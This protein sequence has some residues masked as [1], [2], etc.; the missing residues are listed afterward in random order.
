MAAI[1]GSSPLTR[2]KLLTGESYGRAEWLIPAHA[3]KT[4]RPSKRR[5][6]GRAHPRSR[7]ENA[8]FRAHDETDQGSSPLT[9]G[10]PS[11]GPFRGVA[12]RLI[13]AHAGKTYGWSDPAMAARAHPRSRGENLLHDRV[14]A[15]GGGSSPL[16]RGKHLQPRD[17][18]TVHRLIPAHAGK[19]VLSPTRFGDRTAH[20]RSRGENIWGV[21][22][23]GSGDG[24]SPLTR[25]KRG[26]KTAIASRVGLIPAHAGKTGKSRD[27]LAGRGA[28]PRSRGENATVS[29]DRATQAG[30]SPLTR[31]KR[32][33]C[34]V[35][36][37]RERLIPAH[38]GKT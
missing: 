3:G 20:P 19:T 25:G 23:S 37:P 7:G 36:A 5:T 16:T 38:A 30:S 14:S 27:P 21:G 6:N 35:C 22:C 10:K 12:A 13:P 11:P 29:G 26:R 28:H 18:V 4:A 15:A 17:C 9:R 32:D 31:G 2:G 33:G 34:E 1:V 24:S 8:V